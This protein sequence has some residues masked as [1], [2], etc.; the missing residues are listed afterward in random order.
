MKWTY[1]VCSARTLTD[2]R[3]KQKALRNAAVW[4]LAKSIK[5]QPYSKQAVTKAVGPSTSYKWPVTFHKVCS[6][7]LRILHWIS[8]RTQ[9]GPKKKKKTVFREWQQR[10]LKVFFWTFLT[11]LSVDAVLLYCIHVN[12]KNA[13]SWRYCI[14]LPYASFINSTE[15]LQHMPSCE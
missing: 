5:L 6:N 3:F 15:F 9:S 2:K 11:L 4:L 7:C 1:T 8:K 10:V 12:E 14:S 13:M